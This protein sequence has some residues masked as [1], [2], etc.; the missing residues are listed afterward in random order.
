MSVGQI[1][2]WRALRAERRLRDLTQDEIAA[3]LG[4][5]APAVSKFEKDGTPLPR[6]LTADDY[7]A[8][9]DE[10]TPAVA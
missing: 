3:Q 10:L 5:S 8:A 4:V 7:R 1:E 2:V 9:L 6:D